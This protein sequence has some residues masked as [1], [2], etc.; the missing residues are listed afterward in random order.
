MHVCKTRH[1]R[2]Y[3]SCLVAGGALFTL[4]GYVFF[5]IRVLLYP[6]LCATV[7]RLHIYIIAL[8]MDS[9]SFPVIYLYDTIVLPM[10]R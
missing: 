5:Y 10:Y 1:S 9:T 2:E 8:Y 6:I 7:V 4:Y 3:F